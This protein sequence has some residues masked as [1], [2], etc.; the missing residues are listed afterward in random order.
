MEQYKNK[1]WLINKY[2]REKLS[3][4]QI[5]KLSGISDG[6]IKYFMKKYNISHRSQ[7]EANHL[8]RGNHCELSPKAIKWINGELLGDGCLC[9]QS[10]YSARFSY[11]SKY[12]EYCQ[13]VSNILK[14]FGVKQTGNIREQYYKEYNS[15][16]Y[17]Y[18]SLSYVEL[19]PIYKQWYPN[20]KKIIPKNIKLTPLTMRQWYIGDG[21]LKHPKNGRPTIELATCGFLISDVNWLIRRLSDLGFK[22]TRWITN[23]TINISTKSTKEFLDYI[24]DCPINCY[25]YKFNY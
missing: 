18:T 9:S 12:F 22:A 24:G 7:S 4:N 14:S 8:A 6:T 20:G 1:D 25:K 2:S 19:L 21:Y 23:N 5:A 3:M 13:Y 16:V 15:Y 10:A 17:Y 11:G